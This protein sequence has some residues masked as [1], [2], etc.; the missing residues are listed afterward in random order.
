MA[1]DTDPP[2]TLGITGKW[3]SG[4]TSVMRTAFATLK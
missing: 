4:K 3:G 2:F 1:L